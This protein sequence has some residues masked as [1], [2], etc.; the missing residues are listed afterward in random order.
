MLLR[1]VWS[2]LDY[3]LDDPAEDRALVERFARASRP[4]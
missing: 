3:P 4:T 1:I 2:L